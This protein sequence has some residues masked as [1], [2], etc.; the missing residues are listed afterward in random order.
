[1]TAFAWAH[2]ET[3]TQHKTPCSWLWKINST[4]QQRVMAAL[5]PFQCLQA[6]L[7]L[8]AHE[9]ATGKGRAMSCTL[10]SPLTFA[11]FP[12]SILAL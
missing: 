10:N 3:C 7:N 12:T 11:H 8:A 2:L 5:V 6:S 9:P 1:M 4:R